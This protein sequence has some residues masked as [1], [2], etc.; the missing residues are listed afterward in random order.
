MPGFGVPAAPPQA[1]AWTFHR[2]KLGSGL[3][4]LPFILGATSR[5]HVSS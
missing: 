1:C 4:R 5:C 3:E 2:L